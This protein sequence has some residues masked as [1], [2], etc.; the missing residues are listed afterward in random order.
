[1]SDDR[2]EVR[3][4]LKLYGLGHLALLAGASTMH[5]TGSMLP[6]ACAASASLMLTF[7]LVRHLAARASARARDRDG[8]HR[9][10]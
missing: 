6:M 5:L 7:P 4:V 2:S 8:P 3:R 1:M 9:R 10:R